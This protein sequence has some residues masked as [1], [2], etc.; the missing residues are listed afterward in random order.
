MDH[1]SRS[2]DKE[3]LAKFLEHKEESFF[4]LNKD[5][6][7][8]YIVIDDFL[9]QFKLTKEDLSYA[10]LESE[11]LAN[12]VMRPHLNSRQDFMMWLK[13]MENEDFLVNLSRIGKSMTEFRF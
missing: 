2:L 9:E 7:P 1:E 8:D 13:G 5:E 6:G 11:W 10:H 4:N 3:K 12:E